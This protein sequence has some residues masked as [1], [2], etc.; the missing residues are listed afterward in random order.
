MVAHPYH[1]RHVIPVPM[2]VAGMATDPG[3]DDTVVH[4]TSK[5]QATIPAHLRVKY[6]IQAPGRVRFKEE[7]GR[8][9]VHPVRSPT[10]M[11][12]SLR[13]PKDISLIEDLRR[14]RAEDL[15]LDERRVR[16]S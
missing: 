3:A 15:A 10:Q 5:G 9:V 4:V 13:A 11:M 2:H 14:D 6:G 7:G 16:R 8:L 1:K 12:G